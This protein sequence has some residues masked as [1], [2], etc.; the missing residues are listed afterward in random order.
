M[1]M[2][3]TPSAPRDRDTSEDGSAVKLQRLTRHQPPRY[4]YVRVASDDGPRI[5]TVMAPIVG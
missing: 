2:R 1:R 3:G 5:I 4:D